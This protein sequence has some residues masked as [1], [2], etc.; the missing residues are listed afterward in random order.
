[1][2]GTLAVLAVLLV[3][4]LFTALSDVVSISQARR[5]AQFLPV[6][7]AIAG[8]A[9]LFG[10]LR[11]AGVLLA[12]GAGIALEVAYATDT[13]AG[14]EAPGPTWPIWLAVVGGIC[15]IA[16]AVVLSDRLAPLLEP[17]RWAALAAVAFVVPVAV[18][19]FSDLTR[20]DEP[21]EYALTPGLVEELRRL[22]TDDVVFASPEASYRIGA[23]APVYVAAMPPSHAADTEDNRPYRRQRDAIRFFTPRRFD[24]AERRATLE[25]YGA[26]WLVVDKSR[27]YPRQFIEQFEPVYED[28]RYLLLRV[29]P[30]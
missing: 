16:A 18:V 17:T 6:P 5:L 12:L 15:G 11:L 20:Q 27:P 7:F 26:D 14:G 21:D 24:E 19:G 1:V 3:P 28:D 10:C 9:I 29:V 25:R 22:D 13:S 2:G 4:F 30:T 8:A 23:F